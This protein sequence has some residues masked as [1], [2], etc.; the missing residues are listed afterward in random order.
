MVRIWTLTIPQSSSKQKPTNA[1]RIGERSVRR[2]LFGGNRGWVRPDP[3][4][5]PTYF[6]LG[7]SNNWAKENSMV[8]LS[9]Q[10]TWKY[11]K[12]P[13]RTETR[14]K[15]EAWENARKRGN[16]SDQDA[17]DLSN[18]SD[19]QRK[20]RKFLDL[21]HSEFKAKQKQFQ[22]TCDNQVK[23]IS[24]YVK[25]A[26]EIPRKGYLACVLGRDWIIIGMSRTDS[27]SKN[28][29]SHSNQFLKICHRTKAIS[30]TYV[31]PWLPPMW[32][33]PRPAQLVWRIL[34]RALFPR[35][36]FDWKNFVS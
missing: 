25:S 9:N 14:L 33:D 5:V 4:A 13:L 11:N 16:A 3:Q 26:S 29:G 15:P 34:W 21:A 22:I 17:T 19:W 23:I 24:F 12:G 20:W 36:F 8:S 30:T 7:S 32:L 1:S 31:L 28:S 35:A 10:T 18:E 6:A 2:A 27:N